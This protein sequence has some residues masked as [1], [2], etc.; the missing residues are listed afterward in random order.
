MPDDLLLAAVAFDW[1]R[2][3]DRIDP[4]KW[5]RTA[6][7]VAGA[8]AVILAAVVGYAAVVRGVNA[9]E[10]RGRLPASVAFALRKILRWVTVLVA[11]SLLLAVLGVF[12]SV[13]TALAGVLTLVAAGFVAFWS[14]LS[15]LLCAVILLVARPFQLGDRLTF[16]GD[17]DLTGSVSDFDLLFT[18]LR[19]DDGRLLRVP[20]N[21]FFQ[22]MFL[23]EPADRPKELAASLEAPKSPAEEE[24]K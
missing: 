16:P 6:R 1:G 24:K 4:E 10:R 5:S 17:D 7:A 2:L 15:N 12:E 23:R 18:T 19:L 9:A 22:K 20:N 13:F 14:V 11:G 3:L 8:G 21:L